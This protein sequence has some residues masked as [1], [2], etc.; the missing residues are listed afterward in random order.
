MPNR[1]VLPLESLRMTDVATVGGKN[2]RCE[3]SPARDGV[4]VPAASPPRRRRST[5]SR[6]QQSLERHNAGEG[7][8]RCRFSRPAPIRK[9]VEAAFPGPEKQTAR[10]TPGGRRQQQSK[11]SRRS[12]ATG[13]LPDASFA[14]QQETTP[15][16]ASRTSR[17]RAPRLRLALQ[18]PRHR[19]SRAQLQPRDVDLG[20]HPANGEGATFGGRRLFMMDTE[21]ASA[22]VFITRAT[23]SGDLHKNP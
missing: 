5:I 23:A 6:A 3:P 7:G 22:R 2:G 17:S 10:N 21:S 19:L 9:L 14:G 4:R 18:R 1:Y 11:A 20:R 13:G 8:R 15:F 16:A 12:S